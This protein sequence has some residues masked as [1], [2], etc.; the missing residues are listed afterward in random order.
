MTSLETLKISF[1]LDIKLFDESVSRD[2]GTEGRA[3]TKL[4][5]YKT[6]ACNMLHQRGPVER[7]LDISPAHIARL[8][9]WK[10]SKTRTVIT[11]S[12]WNW[13]HH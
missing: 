13:N 9:R 12:R 6:S 7:V 4:F 3:D 5:R 10:K 1:A 2:I 8:E 11:H